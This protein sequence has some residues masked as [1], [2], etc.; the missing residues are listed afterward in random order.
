MLS[1][2]AAVVY[3]SALIAAAASD[4]S[5]YEIPNGLSIALA[6]GFVFAAFTLRG[7]DLA[8]H[9][10]AGGATFVFTLLLFA[11]GLIGGGDV[12]LMSA[13]ALWVG[14][15]GLTA[16]ALLMAL[17]G[18]GLAAM[19]LAARRL[20]PRPTGGGRWYAHLLAPEAGVPYGI[21]IAGAGLALMPQ[22]FVT[23]A[24]ERAVAQLLA[25]VTGG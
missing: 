1:L 24:A 2:L 7:T 15:G 14:L 5:R 12:K 23:T 11:R 4:L 9:L 22:L 13:T 20:L 25:P 19:L 16:F 17:F 10:A 21:A 3:G 18:A 8:S 6:V